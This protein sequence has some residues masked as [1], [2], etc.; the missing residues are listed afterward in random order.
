M[1]IVRMTTV[2]WVAASALAL[3]ASARAEVTGVDVLERSAFASGMSFG[4]VGAYEKI[5]GIAHFSLDP[6][7]AANRRIVDLEFAPRDARG[8]VTFESAF[9][10]LRPVQARDSTLLYDVNNRGGIAILGQIDG[11]SPVNNDPSSVADAGDGFLMRH[12]FSL[13]FS[14]WT[15]DVA[16]PAPGVKPL[17]FAAPVAHAPDGGS[18]SGPVENEFIVSS[19][20]DI[21]T[22]AGMR[23][24]TYE[25]ATA[26]DPTAI[27]TARAAPGDPRVA[28]ERA[29]W[30]FVAPEQAGGAGRVALDGGFQPGIL[31]EL[32]YTAQ[33]PKVSGAGLAGIRDLL[34]YFHDHPF[35]GALAPRHVLI[36]GISQSGRVI[37]R[38][39]HD[40]LDVDENGRLAFDGAYLQVPGG[41]GSAGFNS[42]FAQPTRHPSALEEHDYPADAFPFTSAVTR[43]PV[44]GASASTLDQARDAHGNLPKIFIANTSTEYWNRDASLVTTTPD[45]TSDVA[46][47]PNVRVYA[48]MGAQ[49]YEGR[50][51]TRFPYVN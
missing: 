41:G 42:R 1:E 18:I 28:V 32:T 22:Y 10:L 7:A 44:T 21:A 45:G 43:D 13:L 4:A 19:P 24:L 30:R 11:A 5:R 14:A 46:P 23:G 17:V 8:R 29:R 6:N 33:D 36:F 47:A 15:W 38:M 2:V 27:L 16:P 40:G 37:G 34:A 48:F 35:E 39:L 49:H 9:I 25:P 26:D 20:Q 51:H 50:S 31:Y 3:L 12:G